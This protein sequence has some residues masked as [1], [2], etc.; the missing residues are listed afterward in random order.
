MARRKAS[1]QRDLLEPLTVYLVR[2]GEAAGDQRP[3]EVGPP[4]TARGERQAVKVARRLAHE[5]F[6][7][8][9]SSD[10]SRA[11]HT[12]Q[13]IIKYHKNTPYTVSADI[14][15]VSGHHVLPGRTPRQKAIQDRMAGSEKSVKRFVDSIVPGQPQIS[16]DQAGI[17]ADPFQQQVKSGA[18]ASDLTLV[19][20]T[21]PDI[22]PTFDDVDAV[23]PQAFEQEP[24]PSQIRIVGSP[25]DNPNS[26]YSSMPHDPVWCHRGALTVGDG[27]R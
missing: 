9:Y 14:R 1:I 4:L 27:P 19:R 18:P 5:E 24:I 7:H 6:D 2:H 20:T 17:A 26:H 25:K 23:L 21:A 13:A 3:G 11:F 12:A 22:R 16:D 8:I 15:E 10:M